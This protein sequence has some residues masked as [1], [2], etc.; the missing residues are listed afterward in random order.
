MQSNMEKLCGKC[1]AIINCQANQVESC[2]C[3]AVNVNQEALIFLS[4]T[5]FDCLCTACLKKIVADL[6]E[7]KRY[8]L[9]IVKEDFIE[10][11][12]YYLDG[13]NWVFTELYHL[14]KGYCCGNN[15]RHCVYGYRSGN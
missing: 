13:N 6:E 8:S 11:L 10:G 9:P 4:K 2:F 3:S 7:S 5:Y 15:C 1:G 14:L 12:H